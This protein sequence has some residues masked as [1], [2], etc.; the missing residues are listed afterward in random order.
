MITLR[1]SWKVLKL[2]WKTNSLSSDNNRFDIED[3]VNT[4]LDENNKEKIIRI[5]HQFNSNGFSVLI[6]YKR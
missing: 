6:H 2:L 1:I 3:K 5:E 4:W